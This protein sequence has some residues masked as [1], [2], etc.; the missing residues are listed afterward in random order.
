M[1]ALVVDDRGFSKNIDGK[2]YI[3]GILL[4]RILERDGK[5]FIQVKDHDR[6]RIKCRHTYFVEMEL[7]TFIEKISPKPPADKLPVEP[8]EADLS[9]KI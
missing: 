3:D 4:F 9:G 2:I 6:Q 8:D 7:E 5:R 1:P